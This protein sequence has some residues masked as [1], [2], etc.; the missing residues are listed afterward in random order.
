LIIF[1]FIGVVIP[2]PG[3]NEK[4]FAPGSNVTLQWTYSDA[5]NVRYWFWYF[6][7]SASGSKEE[8]IA[9]IDSSKN[10]TMVKSSSLHA[11]RIERP[12]TL[13]LENVDLKYDGTYRF[14]LGATGGGE[15]K[16]IV[17]ITGK[18]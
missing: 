6:T 7:S 16:V 17:F 9:E 2:P 14:S 12:A 13:V 15:S 1:N 8:L 3:G 4:Y 5:S 11:V 10:L 18:F